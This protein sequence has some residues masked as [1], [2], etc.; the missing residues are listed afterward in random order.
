[1]NA[2]TKIPQTSVSAGEQ[3]VYAEEFD[4]KVNC[5]WCQSDNNHVVSPFGGTVSEILF[6]CDAC[7]NVFGWMKWDNRLPE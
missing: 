1:M 5:P 4:E 7:E 3:K 6:H 2:A